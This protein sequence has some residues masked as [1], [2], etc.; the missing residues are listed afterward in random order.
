MNDD[1]KLVMVNKVYEEWIGIS[2]RM[3]KDQ[4]EKHAFQGC[5]I[6]SRK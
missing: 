1:E 2:V 3:D 6:Y 4:Y 5:A